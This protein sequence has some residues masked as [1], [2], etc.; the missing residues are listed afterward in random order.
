VRPTVTLRRA[1]SDPGLLGSILDGPSWAAWRTL[2][3]ASMGEALTDDERAIFAKLTGRERESLKRVE[4]LAAIVGRRG[5]KSRAISTLAAYIAGLCDH[6]DKLV[7]GET[8]VVLLIAPDQ[9]QASIGLSYA[10]AAFEQSPILRQLIA[11]RTADTLV[12]TNGISI[13]VRAASFR[14]LRGPTYVAVVADEAAFWMADDSANPDSEILGS[15][16][17]G[18]A[19]TNGLLAIISSPHAKRGELWEV[20]RQHFG[21]AGDPLILVAQ[22]ESRT[23]NPTLPQK[24]VDRAL[25][26]D[27]A[28]ASAE[29]L[30][31]FRSDIE[32][33]VSR[34]QVEACVEVGI[35]ERAP[36]TGI[37]YFSFTD[38]SGGSSDAMVCAIAH[39]EKDTIVVDAVREIRAPF[40]PASATAELAQFMKS[41]RINETTGDRYAAA[42][43]VTAFAKHHIKYKHSELNRSQLYLELL[44]RLNAKAI[45]LL[46]HPHTVNQICLLERRTGRG[47]D[48]VDHPNGAHDD[49]ANGVAGLC[50]VIATNKSTYNLAALVD[51]V[52]NASWETWM[53]RAQFGRTGW[54]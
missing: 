14:R 5:G 44:P 29:Y 45:R 4:E 38:P 39:R 37:K 50:G 35:R 16:R 21:A 25:A 19:T 18:L 1:L 43:V 12:L 13:E 27:H 47:R 26:R 6:S 8:G 41:Y 20:Y 24:V 53:Q 10:S 33:F 40:D 2:L 30:G 23:F 28:K 49:L 3:I 22:G 32:S 9:R 48:T 51:D 11:G 52:P 54:F 17:P 7:P 31:Q 46:D 42:W 15:V 36:A 34:E